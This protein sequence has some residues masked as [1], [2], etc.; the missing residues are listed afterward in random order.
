[1]RDEIECKKLFRDFV[2]KSTSRLCRIYSR[3]PFY[4]LAWNA[5]STTAAY[6]AV[7]GAYATSK[8][9]CFSQI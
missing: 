4:R 1:M 2:R 9:A 6:E 8:Q 5:I 7:T 3:L